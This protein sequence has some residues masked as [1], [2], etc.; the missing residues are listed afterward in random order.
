MLHL[1]GTNGGVVFDAGTW[2]MA[3]EAIRRAPGPVEGTRGI[4][5]HLKG[6]LLWTRI[7]LTS[8][9]YRYLIKNVNIDLT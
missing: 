6:S 1:E 4:R 3:Y 7:C 2:K 5:L 8:T 9:T